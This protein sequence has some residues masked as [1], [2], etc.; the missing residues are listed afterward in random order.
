MGPK[1]AGSGTV[2]RVAVPNLPKKERIMLNWIISVLVLLAGGVLGASNL[3][4]AKKPDA[5]ALIEKLSP[6]QGIIGAL[7]CWRGASGA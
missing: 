7:S 2:T 4:V 6:Y 3:I 5:K 1:A